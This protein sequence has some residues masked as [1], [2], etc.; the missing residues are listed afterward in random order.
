VGG[1]VTREL[2]CH[3][4]LLE[5]SGGEGLFVGRWFSGVVVV[6]VVGGGGGGGGGGVW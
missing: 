5:K 2:G 4:H 1:H 6:V 3:L